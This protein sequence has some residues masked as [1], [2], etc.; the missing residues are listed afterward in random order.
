MDLIYQR[1]EES[2]GLLNI[3]VEKQEHLDAL[4]LM[5]EGEGIEPHEL[6]SLAE[7]LE[8]ICLDA[9]FTHAWILQESTSAGSLQR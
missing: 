4:N 8:F 7:V 1:A 3:Y 6:E 5:F 9:W 2:V